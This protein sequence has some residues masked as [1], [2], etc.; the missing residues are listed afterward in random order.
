MSIKLDNVQSVELD[1]QV[2]DAELLDIAATWSFWNQPPAPSIPRTVELPESL[3]QRTALVIQGVR[4]CGKST[5]MTQLIGRYRLKQR[6]CLFA[7]FEDPRLAGS[8]RFETLEQLTRAFE[9]ARPTG[10]LTVFL[11][12]IQWVEGWERWL[13]T[14]LERPGRFQFVVSGS[15]AHLLS[16]ELSTVLTGRH[17]TV[18]L[19]PF[20]FTEFL[21][22]HAEATVTD[23]LHRGGFPEPIASDAGDSLLRQY[24]LDILQRDVRE[25]TGARSSLSL[26]QIVQMVFESAGSELSLRRISAASGMAVETVSTYLDAC[27]HAYLLFACPWFAYSERK[28]ALRNRKYYPVDTALRRVAVTR[29]GRDLGKALEGATFIELKKRHRDVFYWR[30]NGDT[31]EVDFVVQAGAGPTPVQVTVDGATERHWAALDAFYEAFP[32]ATEPL[33]V[34]LASFPGILAQL[35]DGALERR[36]AGTVPNATTTP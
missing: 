11:D 36:S 35:E 12:E 22:L 31:G 19:F 26:R 27:E 8:L 25:R 1:R 29:A 24:F 5:L 28:R 32:H 34:T 33:I 30:A 18:E 6:D 15:N 7:N 3:S 23:Y 2:D 20:D 13:R 16:G 14:R 9:A 21:R 17:I 4:R 10:T